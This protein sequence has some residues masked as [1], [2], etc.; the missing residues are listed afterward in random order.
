MRH[1]QQHSQYTAR[2]AGNQDNAYVLSFVLHQLHDAH[3]HLARLGNAWHL[4][5]VSMHH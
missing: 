4:S 2:I 1:T 5:V 3:Q